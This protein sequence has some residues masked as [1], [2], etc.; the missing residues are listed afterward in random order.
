MIDKMPC[1]RHD[2]ATIFL[3][4]LNHTNKCAF[5]APRRI[6]CLFSCDEDLITM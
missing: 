2:V 5:L 6:P 4:D 1:L 3:T